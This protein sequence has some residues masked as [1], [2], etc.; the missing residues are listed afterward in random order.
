MLTAADISNRIVLSDN[1]KVLRSIKEETID[2]I[3][4]D[5]LYGTGKDFDAFQDIKSEKTE[6]LNHYEPRISEMK[7][8]LKKEGQ[9]YLQM[10]WRIVHWIRT[11]MDD[12]FG[13]KN[14]RNEII[15]QY[16]SAP[17]AR[18]SFS[19]RHDT[20]L[21]Y[22]KSKHFYFND[23]TVREP[24]KSL[25]SKG[26]SIG[27]YYS[28]L[29]KVMG[30]VWIDIPMLPQKDQKERV[31]Y[32]T[33]KPIQLLERIILSS[34]KPGDLIADFYCG[35]GTTCVVSKMHNRKYFG[36][37]ISTTAY[38]TSQKRLMDT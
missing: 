32:P 25:P 14:F 1:I 9:I 20:I 29:G 36:V 26:S 28:E 17:R 7:R 31:G 6:I 5:I 15:W 34:S 27:K 30:D 37:D 33:Q 13:Y 4:C 3:Y 22:S 12:V 38:I 23:T 10:D 21:R 8:V 24:Y 2:L 19:K 18:K 11:I 35:S 16:D